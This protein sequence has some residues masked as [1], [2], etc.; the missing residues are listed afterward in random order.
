V[1]PQLVEQYVAPGMVFFEYRDYAFRGADAS[2]AAEASFCAAEQDRF[3]QFHD[4]VFENQR[5]LSNSGEGYSAAALRAM[6][7]GVGLDMAAYDSCVAS[8]V[9][10][11]TVAAELDEGQAQG[12]TGTPALFVNGVQIPGNTFEDLQV[13]IAAAL[14]E[15]GGEGG[16]GATPAGV[17]TPA[18][19]ATPATGATPGP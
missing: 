1:K 3:W 8:D 7:E 5:R 6:A 2:R 11:Q 13:A 10:A 14:A 9:P 18:G 16:S 12:V 15:T 17:A 19:G 4:T